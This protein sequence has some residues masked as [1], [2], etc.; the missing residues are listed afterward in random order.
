MGRQSSDVLSDK[1]RC[2]SCKEAPECK[3][4]G[5]C[6]RCRKICQD[7]GDPLPPITTLPTLRLQERGA[8]GDHEDEDNVEEL[9]KVSAKNEM[10]LGKAK[11]EM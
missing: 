8:F 1:K 4:L 3:K 10:I 2:E 5:L 6:L 11:G 7:A 9:A